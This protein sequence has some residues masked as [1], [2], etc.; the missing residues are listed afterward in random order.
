MRNVDT[1]VRRYAEF[2]NACWNTVSPIFADD[3]TGSL[4]DDW[5]QG[6]WELLVEGQL[7]NPKVILQVYGN[8]ADC[9]GKS[10]RVLYPEQEETHEIICKSIKN[11]RIY[12]EF[13]RVDIT[14]TPCELKFDRFVNVSKEGWYYE[15]SPF[16][17]ALCFQ[18]GTE[19]IINI[20]DIEFSVVPTTY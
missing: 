8:G 20:R 7:G 9:N 18:N 14:P 15:E 11:V 5:L 4:K 3:K 2:L 6:N 13:N 1:I 17:K 19:R 16:D 12:D 10:S